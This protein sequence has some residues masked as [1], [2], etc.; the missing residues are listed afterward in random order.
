[1]SLFLWN[2]EGLVNGGSTATAGLIFC[3][4]DRRV[5]KKHKLRVAGVGIMPDTDTVTRSTCPNYI[6]LTAIIEI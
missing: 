2:R 3:T 4:M 1:M 5:R 6:Q